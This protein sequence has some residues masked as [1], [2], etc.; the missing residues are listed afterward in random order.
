MQHPLYIILFQQWETSVSEQWFFYSRLKSFKRI[1]LMNWPLQWWWSFL[2]ASLNTCRRGISNC[3]FM[4]QPT[5][6]WLC[7]IYFPYKQYPWSWVFTVLTSLR[8]DLEQGVRWESVRSRAPGK[9][10]TVLLNSAGR[11]KELLLISICSVV[12]LTLSCVWMHKKKSILV[13]WSLNFK[14]DHCSCYFLYHD[15]CPTPNTSI[16]KEG[17]REA[18]LLAA[19]IV[20][21]TNAPR[22]RKYKVRGNEMQDLL[23]KKQSHALFCTVFKIG[24][25][26]RIK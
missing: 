2:Y 15:I 11:G 21:L 12:A 19:R 26:F 16:H 7:V 8:M 20:P 24:R 22:G 23:G 5:W 18:F 3:N 13:S 17:A 6:K 1:F 9:K 14:K 4:R 25:S 10:H